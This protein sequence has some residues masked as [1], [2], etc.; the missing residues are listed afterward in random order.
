MTTGNDTPPYALTARPRRA[1]PARQNGSILLQISAVVFIL[2]G[3]VIGVFLGS[4][5]RDW[6]VMRDWQPVT[7]RVESTQLDRSQSD[8]TTTYR[9]RATY[10]Y[11]FGGRRFRGTRVGIS[12]GFDNI[13]DYHRRMHDRL[14]QARRRGTPVTAWVNPE[15]PNETVLDRSLRWGRLAMAAAFPLAF[16]G[17]GAGLLVWLSR[18]KA[19]QARLQRA[20][21]RYPDQPWRWRDEWRSPTLRS[22]GRARFRLALIFA[23][24]WNGVSSPVL[25]TVPEE[26]ASGNHAA[27]IALLFPLIGIG[28]IV[29]AVVEVKRW[30]RYGQSTLTLDR[31][32]V[33]LGGRLG[34]ELAVPA[35]LESRELEIQLACIHRY[36]TG[37]GKNRNTREQVLWEDKRRSPV[38]AGHGRARS[39]ARIQMPLPTSGHGSDWQNPRNR[40][41]WELD[42]RAPEPGVDYHAR[43]ELPVFDTGLQSE[44]ET[45][46]QHHQPTATATSADWLETGVRHGYTAG[47]YRFHFPRFRKPAAGLVAALFALVFG[48]IAVLV[49]RH[50]G[51]WIIGGFCALFVPLIGWAALTLLLQRSEILIG[52]DRLRYRHGV[53]GRWKSI[54]LDSIRSFEIKKTGSLG[55]DLY[56]RIG[57]SR[58]GHRGTVTVADWIPGER[59]TRALAAEFARR[60]GTDQGLTRHQA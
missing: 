7:A 19:A 4:D 22:R 43:F 23:V 60:T 3:L 54:P 26:V 57:L 11:R 31:V 50:A 20:R 12:R 16:G 59:P 46:E 37:H 18:N 39:V 30:R 34:A 9:V 28:L 1:A 45:T 40:I 29:W 56:Y 41:I 25:F 42:A 13:G 15:Q 5:L 2:A 47:G 58:W 35:R 14:D 44:R 49:I 27:L 8:G 36:I 24:V 48:A 33:P 17:F 55:R 21:Q 51:H 53:F 10:H 32:P 38:T 6:L 52:S